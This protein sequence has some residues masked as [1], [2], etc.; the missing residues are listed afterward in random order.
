MIRSAE[1]IGPDFSNWNYVFFLFFTD[2]LRLMFGQT[3]TLSCF[4]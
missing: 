2:V 4:V 3:V 1:G